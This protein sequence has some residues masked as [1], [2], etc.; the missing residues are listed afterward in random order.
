MSGEGQSGTR[1]SAVGGLFGLNLPLPRVHSR[2]AA[3]IAL[4]LLTLVWGFNWIAMK[5]ALFH[6]HPLEFNV[7]RIW[8]AVAPEEA[9][10]F[11]ARYGY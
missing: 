9:G 6:A 10:R 1:R 7:Q 2:R 5:A 11:L 8:L 4:A 3:Y